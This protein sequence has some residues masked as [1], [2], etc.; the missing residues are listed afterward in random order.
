VLESHLV[1]VVAEAIAQPDAQLGVVR[2]IFGGGIARC[3][4]HQLKP[5]LEHLLCL[6]GKIEEGQRDRRPLS[7]KFR[8]VIRVV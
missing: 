3:R 8:L 4:V 2:V 1:L 5:V 7:R 6:V